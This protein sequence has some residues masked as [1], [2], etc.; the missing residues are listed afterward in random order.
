MIKELRSDL[1]EEAEGSGFL[2]PE[3]VKAEGEYLPS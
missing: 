3:E 2:N 1:L